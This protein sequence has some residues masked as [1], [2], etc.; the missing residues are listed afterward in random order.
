VSLAPIPL[1]L[2][3]IYIY[4]YIYSLE[5]WQRAQK[6][7]SCSTGKAQLSRKDEPFYDDHKYHHQFVL[8]SWCVDK[9]R[10]A[11]VSDFYCFYE[12]FPVAARSKARD[13]RCSSAETVVSNP[14]GGWM[15]VCCECF[16]LSGRD[17]CDELITHPDK[18]YWL[19]CYSVCDLELSRIR[20]PWPTLGHS[21]TGQNPLLWETYHKQLVFQ[22]FIL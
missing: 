19:W 15:S 4:I 18:S 7:N 5:T 14:A 6:L 20:R 16:V 13:C 1:K 8:V 22:Q 17:L 12:P 10:C 21:A 2:K 11:Y 9:M 3:D